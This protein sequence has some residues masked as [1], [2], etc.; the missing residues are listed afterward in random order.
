MPGHGK[1]RDL[2]LLILPTFSILFVITVI[3]IIG[4]VSISTLKYSLSEPNDIRFIGMRN[5]VNLFGDDRFI[6]SIVVT[7]ELIFIPVILQVF[8]GVCLAPAL[9]ERLRGTRWMRVFFLVPSIIPPVVIGL[10]WKLFIIPEQGG[11][12]FFLNAVGLGHVKFDFLNMPLSALIVIITA[13]VWTGTPYVTLMMISAL[14]TI[15]P[16]HYEAAAIDGAGW[17]RSHWLIS[18]PLLSKT[19]KTVTVFRCLE[20]LAVFPIIFILTGGGPASAT[21]P[22][23]FYAYITS[24]DYL[25]IGYAASIIVFFFLILAGMSA[26]FLVSMAKDWR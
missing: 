24:F 5:F 6:N 16:N 14:E 7:L 25:N 3:P 21:E 11:L 18:L 20:A 13:S 22:I 26:P 15:S 2:Y 17:F 10:I 1:N 12:T 9:N 8:L 4:T 23:N 19:I